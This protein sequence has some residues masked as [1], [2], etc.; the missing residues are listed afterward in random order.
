MTPTEGGIPKCCVRTSK[1]IPPHIRSRIWSW[2]VQHSNGACDINAVILYV[3]GR[4]KALCAHPK[5]IQMLRRNLKTSK[6]RI[7]NT[8]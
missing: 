3:E 5:V 1:H 2:Q 8:V 4:T 6:A 7:L